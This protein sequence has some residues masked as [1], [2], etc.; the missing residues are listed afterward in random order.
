MSKKFSRIYIA[1]LICIFCASLASSAFATAS[2]VIPGKESGLVVT[3][4]WMADAAGQKILDMGGNAIDAAAAV[5]Y[6]LAVV[7][8]SVGNIGG[9]GFALIYLKDKGE[10]E[11]LD[12][13]ETAPSAMH[14]LSFVATDSADF[15]IN[16]L[17]TYQARRYINP[18]TGRNH[19]NASSFGYLASGVPGS[20]AGFCE[21]V[22]KY[23][24]GKV[25]IAQIM[26]PAIQLAEKGHPLMANRSIAAANFDFDGTKKHFSKDGVN[27]QAGEIFKQPA[28]AETLKRIA[29]KPTSA[30][31]Y[32]F[33]EGA[34]ADF[35]V[36]DV[37]KYG[38]LITH[39]DLANYKNLLKWRKPVEGTY[40][41]F[42]VFSMCPPS[43]G[44]THIIQMLN[45]VENAPIGDRD[46]GYGFK[47][48]KTIWLMT[49]AQRQAYAD[50]SEYMGD[51][52]TAALL[53]I[54]IPVDKLTS[55]DYA[56]EIYDKIVVSGDNGNRAIPSNEII[57]GFGPLSSYSGGGGGPGTET[58]HYSVIDKDGNAVAITY[59]INSGWGCGAVVDG[60]GFFMNDELDDFET[61]PNVINAFGQIRYEI[62]VPSGDKRPLSSM[63]P[64]MVL[65]ESDNSL[66]LVT[67]S[68]GGRTIINTNFHC[69]VNAIDHS[70]NVSQMTTAPRTDVQWYPDSVSDR[71][72]YEPMY[73]FTNDTLKELSDIGYTYLTTSQGNVDAIMVGARTGSGRA[74]T[75][76]NDPRS[77]YEPFAYGF[78]APL[79]LGAHVPDESNPVVGVT[80]APASADVLS[81]GSSLSI[82]AIFDPLNAAN[83]NVT[84]STSDSTLATVAPS[85][86]TVITVVA[87]NT[88]KAGTVT[89]TA[90]TEDGNKTS[91]CVVTVKPIE[92]ERIDLDKTSLTLYPGGSDTITATIAPANATDKNVTWSASNTAVVS[93]NSNAGGTVMATAISP[94]TSTITA[95]AGGKTAIITATVSPVPVESVALN[96]TSLTLLTGESE[97]L[98]ATVLPWN[99]PQNVTWSTSDNTIATVTNGT[100]TANSSGKAG[101]VLITA[102][103]E[104]ASATC[105]VTV[106]TKVPPTG[107]G[108]ILPGGTEVDLPGGAVI[109]PDG[110]IK[111]PDNEGGTA[112]TA[113]GL[114]IGIPG[115]TVITSDGMIIL[116]PNEEGVLELPGA[117]VSLPGGTVILPDGTIKM[118]ADEGGVLTTSD[119]VEVALPEGTVIWP[120]GTVAM[121][122]DSSATVKTPDGE[123]ETKVSGS[124]RIE[125]DETITLFSGSADNV[126]ITTSDGTKIVLQSGSIVD[127]DTFVIGQGG[128]V[129]IFP[130]GKTKA[131]SKDVS[132]KVNPDG[133]VDTGK[134]KGRGG[135]DLGVGILA[136][137]IA[138]I[139]LFVARRKLLK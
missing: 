105:I 68:P 21:M 41:G 118:P 59:T 1:V 116:P 109:D 45:V 5:G 81:D 56:K 95:A 120:D 103:A 86:G 135:C 125:A 134:S 124:F 9:G 139:G 48:L 76:A 39:A 27:Y 121:P 19:G 13:R 25:T 84:W 82:R 106:N 30:D 34:T 126:T 28:L 80:V 94:G 108:I 47:A 63:S 67:G 72:N 46:A 78:T 112:T 115:G 119:G 26:E 33:Y 49:Q 96:K 89:I 14:R 37:L 132:I 110:T 71:I 85:T 136:C 77:F 22:A 117:D 73:G 23:G 15:D 83:Q 74:V 6:A 55:K 97:T 58:T 52:D 131:I 36:A 98:I 16:D 114:V 113:G 62:N 61:V 66:F 87:N 65:R 53:G 129:I 107:G 2:R 122:P 69:I 20:P 102:A 8:P 93:L 11:A 60:A 88:G 128:A 133:S 137:I 123:V 35:I 3:M 92:V 44:G 7:E 127:G 12:F 79:K 31:G 17:S 99:A 91:A 75:G 50:R 4:N 130:D 70:M 10:I 57:P 90:T 54:T 111:L 32:G 40:R 51:P 24:S 104:N 38:G 43:S 64:T 101:R 100:V 138:G 42:K 18:I 29:A